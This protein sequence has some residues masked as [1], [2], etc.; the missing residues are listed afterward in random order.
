MAEP[1]LH[2]SNDNIVPLQP[3]SVIHVAPDQVTQRERK[4]GP[5][6]D[7]S[8]DSRV[9]QLILFSGLLMIA[10]LGAFALIAAIFRMF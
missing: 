10:V 4:R 1:E 2:P 6:R 5:F 8:L 3:R 7:V 9:M